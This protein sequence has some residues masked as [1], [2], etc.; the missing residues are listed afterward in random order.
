M[1][2]YTAYEQAVIGI[3][4]YG[5][6]TFLF[7]LFWYMPT[8]SRTQNKDYVLTLIYNNYKYIV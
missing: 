7:M 1:Y 3:I 8:F 4:I 2:T 5:I 6:A